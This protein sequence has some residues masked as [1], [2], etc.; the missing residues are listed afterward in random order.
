[1]DKFDYVSMILDN[2]I[3]YKIALLPEF[4]GNSLEDHLNSFNEKALEIIAGFNKILLN[5][6]LK[7]SRGKSQGEIQADLDKLEQL[8]YLLSPIG[9]LNYLGE[10]QVQFIIS[11]L[12]DLTL[13]DISENKI[14]LMA[15]DQ[16]RVQFGSTSSYSAL[17]ALESQLSSAAFYLMNMGYSR[18][19][20]QEK[21][22]EVR[23]DPAKLESLFSLPQKEI[24]N[25][26][27]EIQQSASG[28]LVMSEGSSDSTNVSSDN[29]GYEDILAHHIQSIHQDITAE[30]AQ[31]VNEILS[32]IKAHVKDRLT[33]LQEQVFRQMHPDRLNRALKMLKTTKRKSKRMDLYLE[34]FVS[35]FLLS[36]IELK[37]EHWQ[38]SSS[39]G[40]G[41]AGVYTAGIDFSRYDNIIRDFP[42]NKLEKVVKITRRIIRSPTK[43]AIQ[44][45]G[46]DLIA[47]TGFDEH[48]YFTD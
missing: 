40:H 7:I 35:S 16:L 38:V 31:K 8:S 30:R 47:E 41:S 2:V 20:I 19:E 37:V 14:S 24:Y 29:N 17:D 39:A 4:Q 43:K 42:D 45:L 28:S 15:D 48:L 1:M 11:K 27:S 44:K 32:M 5:H 10:E 3:V 25:V 21:F 12:N 6:F 13:K 9:N 18:Q 33:D 34:W 23:Q 26:P 36:K 22:N 46:Q